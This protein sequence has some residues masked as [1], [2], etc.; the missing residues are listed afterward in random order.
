MK[1][2]RLIL[3]F[4]MLAMLACAGCAGWHIHTEPC[5]FCGN[6]DGTPGER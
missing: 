4:A 6:G 3:A 5:E 1:R 2:N